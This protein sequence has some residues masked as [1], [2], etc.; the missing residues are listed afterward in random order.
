MPQRGHNLAF[1]LTPTE[2][3]TLLEAFEARH[4]VSYHRAGT[5][6]A[7]NAPALASLAAEESLR[8]LTIGDWNHSPS[9]L[10]TFPDEGVV[11][12]EITM[13]K[14][15]YAYAVG[16]RENPE[17]ARLR[18]SGQ[19]AEGV[20][21]AGSLDTYSRSSYSGLLFQAL[22]KLIKQRS[23]RIGAF[24]V[25]REAEE[26]LQRGWRLVTIASSPQEYDLIWE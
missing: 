3:V 20:L 9:Y 10:L 26:Q 8:R 6:A 2:Q 23:R 15:G 18:P 17:L 1:F 12:R 7:P 14:G 4:R 19:F 22:A 25:G 16:Q 5:S 24:W 13:R 11:V 21:V